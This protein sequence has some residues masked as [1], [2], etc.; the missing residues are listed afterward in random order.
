[1]YS[2]VQKLVSDLQSTISPMYPAV[3][4]RLLALLPRTIP[5]PVLTELL[6]TFSTLFKYL[7]IST[8]SDL[9]ASENLNATW[10][11][12]SSTLPKCN[13]EVQRAMAE[14][15]GAVLRRLKGSMRT[16][17]VNLIGGSVGSIAD[18][19][20]WVVVSACKVRGPAAYFLFVR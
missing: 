9:N 2:L 15:W 4:E 13:P 1:M 6:S 14:V 19:T 3:L 10:T 20:A 8:S 11:A 5:A 18:A 16:D 17:A 12:L 7:L